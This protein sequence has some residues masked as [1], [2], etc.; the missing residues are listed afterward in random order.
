MKLAQS[1]SFRF[2]KISYSESITQIAF[3]SFHENRQALHS[4]SMLDLEITQLLSKG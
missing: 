3:M 2:T 1:K 4:N